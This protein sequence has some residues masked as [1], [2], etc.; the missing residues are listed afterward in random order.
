MSKRIRTS[1]C[2]FG[3]RYSTIELYSHLAD[4]VPSARAARHSVLGELT[5]SLTFIPTLTA[6][7]TPTPRDFLNR[8]TQRTILRGW[9]QSSR[10]RAFMN[11]EFFIGLLV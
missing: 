3:D 8:L 11:Q 1:I 9:L 6:N 7:T 4:H 10:P 5:I 2:G